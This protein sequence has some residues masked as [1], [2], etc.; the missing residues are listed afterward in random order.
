MNEK[1]TRRDMLQKSGALGV[2][3]VVGAGACSKPVPHLSC[4]DTTSLSSADAQVR[5]ALMYIDNSTEP[6]KSCSGCQQFL[7]G[8]ADACGSCKVL[9][10]PINPTGYCKSFVVKTS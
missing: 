1:L 5:T 6:G 2:L 9:R 8:P 4:A 3:A 10:G 7:P